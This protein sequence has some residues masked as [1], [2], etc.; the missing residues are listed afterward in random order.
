LPPNS[1][2]KRE[3]VHEWILWAMFESTPEHAS[4]EWDEEINEYI[5]IVEESL[6]RKLEPGRTPGVQS[7]RLSFD[8]IQMLH[9]PLI[10]YIVRAVRHSAF[11]H[12]IIFSDCCA[13]R[14]SHFCAPPF[15]RIQT[16]CP[17]RNIPHLSAA[18]TIVAFLKT[19]CNSLFPL[20]VPPPTRRCRNKQEPD[21]FS[22][23][24]WCPS[25]L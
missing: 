23:W 10:W 5:S 8:P 19:R 2:I 7:L 6:G 18:S 17:T 1:D 12:L 22:A 11:R 3:N 25:I 14:Y 15:S 21:S 13:S 16:L 24:H 4:P 20:L 9:R